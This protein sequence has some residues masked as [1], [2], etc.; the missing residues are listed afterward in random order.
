MSWL[1]PRFHAAIDLVVCVGRPSSGAGS[2]NHF[3]VGFGAV[4]DFARHGPRYVQ[5]AVIAAK[6]NS[7]QKI[8]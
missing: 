4:L 6:K 8:N 1:L 2:R 5:R 3:G 7:C